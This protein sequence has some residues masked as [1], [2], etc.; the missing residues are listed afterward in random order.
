M[1][2]IFIKAIKASAICV[3]IMILVYLLLS[4]VYYTTTHSPSYYSTI[5]DND[6]M[7]F[8]WLLLFIYAS[9]ILS[10]LIGIISVWLAYRWTPTLADALI[11]SIVSGVTTPILFFIFSLLFSINLIFFAFLTQGAAQ[12]IPFISFIIEIGAM[13]L[14]ALVFSPL[15]FGIS[16]VF[17]TIGGLLYAILAIGIRLAIYAVSFLLKR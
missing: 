12:K 3:I 16:I 9:V 14:T 6:M 7:G 2:K 11:T 10:L 1:K 8:A 4:Y 17:T 13:Y 15:T 5:Y